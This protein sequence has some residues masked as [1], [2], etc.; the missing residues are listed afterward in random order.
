[1]LGSRAPDRAALGKGLGRGV[2]QRCWSRSVQGNGRLRVPSAM[3]R[4]LPC[5]PSIQLAAPEQMEQISARLSF[6]RPLPRCRGCPA[7]NR[8]SRGSR[9]TAWHSPRPARAGG[10]GAAVA[11]P[12]AWW[13]RF[14]GSLEALHLNSFARHKFHLFC[15]QRVCATRP[16]DV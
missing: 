12:P 14:L 9:G 16:R 10:S 8:L 15:L 11:H 13:L 7:N 4:A 6:L 2:G 5:A 3:S 1:M